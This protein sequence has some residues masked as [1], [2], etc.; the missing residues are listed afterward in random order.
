MTPLGFSILNWFTQNIYAKENKKYILTE[1]E[2]CILELMYGYEEGNFCTTE[3]IADKLKIT[4]ERVRQLLVKCF[5][6]LQ[7]LQSY[8]SGCIRYL[9]HSLYVNKGN[10][11]PDNIKNAI[12]RIWEREMPELPDQAILQLLARLFLDINQSHEILSFYK[13]YKR[14]QFKSQSYRAKKEKRKSDQ[15]EKFESLIKHKTI[16]FDQIK[17]WRKDSF[18][19]A[20]PKRSTHHSDRKHTGTIYSD[21]CGRNIQY[22]SSI[23]LAFI[24]KLEMTPTVSHYLEQPVKIKYMR[25]N[26]PCEYTPDF[27]ILLDDGS[28]IV[29]EIKCSYDDMMDADVQKKM[30]ALI[31]FCDS[32]G[33]GVLISNGYYSIDYLLTHPINRDLEKCIQN[34]LLEGGGREILHYEFKSICEMYHTTKTDALAL[35]LKNNWG[36]YNYPFKLTLENPNKLFREKIILRLAETSHIQ[37]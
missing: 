20:E 33:M 2:R 34:K 35:I 25:G 9:T 29:A 4:P 17:R 23:E 8:N 16:W 11:N 1:R 7:H 18:I 3:D 27:A 21:K 14:A 22:E 13:T 24:R 5:K 30:E 6:K 36:Y 37:R 28:C 19:K 10:D 12:I 32:S 31:K 15:I 26:K